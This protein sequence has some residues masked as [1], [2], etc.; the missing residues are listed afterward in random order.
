LI[1]NLFFFIPFELGAR[2]GGLYL[3]LG[4]IHLTSVIGIYIGIINRAREFFWILVGLILTQFDGKHKI[5]K[6]DSKKDILK[7]IEENAK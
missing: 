7:F 5:K 1:T 6:D 4:S 2:E 3:V